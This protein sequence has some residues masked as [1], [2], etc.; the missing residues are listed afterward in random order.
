MRQSRYDYSLCETSTVPIPP[1][2]A[3]SSEFEAVEVL[4]HPDAPFSFRELCD[5]V[6]PSLGENYQANTAY[7]LT[8]LHLKLEYALLGRGYTAVLT[9][10]SSFYDVT[11]EH[12]KYLK[13]A[14]GH[15]AKKHPCEVIFK[16]E[17]M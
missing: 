11:L 5:D 2:L 9:F 17:T 16:P 10:D 14:I 8:P 7:F 15:L 4:Y 1:E 13:K 3:I 12:M 6:L